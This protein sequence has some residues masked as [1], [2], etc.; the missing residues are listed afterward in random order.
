[1]IAT[2]PADVGCHHCGE[3][4][5]PGDTLR[6]HP[7]C[8]NQLNLDGR[9]IDR[10]ATLYP[11]IWRGGKCIMT[12]ERSGVYVWV[13]WLSRFMAGDVA[14]EWA[15]WFRSH[16]QGYT[17]APSDFD[18]ADWTIKHTRLL[19]ELRR[20]KEKTADQVL[21]EGQ[22]Q[23]YYERP[24]TG[25]TVSGKPDL[26]AITGN[27]VEVCDC[28][29]GQ[30]RTSDGVQV[31]LYMYCILRSNPNLR[32]KTFKGQLV[33]RDHREDIPPSV[34]NEEFER[35]VDFF[36]DMLDTPTDSPPDR[37]PSASECRF[38]DI[39][40]AECPERIDEPAEDGEEVEPSA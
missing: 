27:E 21:V 34:I 2:A 1:M 16:F 37:T 36:L 39:G 5:F 15:P 11:Q 9:D 29:T 4:T 32:G 20:E 14:C 6:L 12:V 30:P 28:K 3:E 35:N 10:R 23:F 7:W 24:G 19:T 26:L 18:L 25:L 22:T 40:S 8:A 17:K 33:Y 31:R 38:C 13:T